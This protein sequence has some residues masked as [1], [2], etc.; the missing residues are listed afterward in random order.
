MQEANGRAAPLNNIPA[1]QAP[2][3]VVIVNDKELVSAVLVFDKECL[4]TMKKPT[5]FECTALL[6][7]GYFVFQI[8]Y[9]GPYVEQL[10]TIQHILHAERNYHKAVKRF[11]TTFNTAKQILSEIN[12]I[13]CKLRQQQHK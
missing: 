3:L 4:Y 2:A 8:E 12:Q 9:P 13:D 10:H 6:L 1:G 11:F 5:A 7:S